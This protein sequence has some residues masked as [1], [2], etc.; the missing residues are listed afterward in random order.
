MADNGNPF[1]TDLQGA[2]DAIRAMMTPPDG[3]NVEVADAPVE[4]EDFDDTEVEEAVEVEAAEEPDEGE[5]YEEEA[6]DEPQEARTFTVKVNGEEIEVTEDELLNG[7]SRQQ[8][9]TRKAQELAE[10][11]KAVEAMDNELDAERQQYEQL[12][13]ALHQQLQQL[14]ANEPNWDKLYEENPTEAIKLERQWKRLQSERQQQLE[15]VQQEQQRLNTIKQRRLQE[16]AQR[17]LT[18]EQARLPDL[19]PAWK[20]QTVAQK[21]ATEIREF[22]LGQGFSEPDVDGIKSAQLIAVARAAMLYSRG[23]TN[24]NKAKAARKSGPKTMKPGSRGTQPQRR[25]AQQKAQ[26]RLAKSGRVQDAAAV[27]KGLL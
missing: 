23:E 12:L 14:T 5:Y 21:E 17:Q 25:G 16:E 11:R 19:I 18:A 26:Q 15:A 10:R 7:Y 3:D 2:Q 27:I 4:A 13:P 24:V 22:L 1:G 8:D 6:A 9:Y 20:D